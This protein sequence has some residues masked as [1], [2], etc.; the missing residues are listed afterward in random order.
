MS[1]F[2]IRE[3]VDS[4][5]LLSKSRVVAFLFRANYSNHS[6]SFSGMSHIYYKFRSEL[7]SKT[8][9]FDTLDVSVE[10]FKDRVY[11][12]EQLS[13]DIFDLRV[14]NAQ[15]KREYKGTDI[16]PR[17]SSVIV[18]RLPSSNARK[19]PKVQ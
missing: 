9:N 19:M 18:M 1:N 11:E 4:F 8:A 6:L 17:N 2:E 12:H 14:E 13:P 15:S 10:D 16:I 5:F 7:A 3:K